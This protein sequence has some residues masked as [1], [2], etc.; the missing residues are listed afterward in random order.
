MEYIVSNIAVP[1]SV[2]VS[3]HLWIRGNF[4]KN[5]DFLYLLDGYVIDYRIKNVVEYLNLGLE[6]HYANGA[7]NIFCFDKQNGRLEI[8]T[9]KRATL[10]LYLYEKDGVFAY[11]NNP[12]LLVKY[13]YDSISISVES[14]KSQLLYFT[15]YH[16]TRTLFT[17]ISRVDGATYICYDILRNSIKKH[18]YWDFTYMPDSNLGIKT[19]LEKVDSDF[20]YYFET[21]KN[22]NEG[23]LAG[24]GCSGGLDS[25]IIA[26]YLHKVGIRSRAYVFGDEKPHRFLRST[27]AKTSEM[28]GSSYGFKVDFI[29]YRAE[30]ITRS[31]ILDIRN[32]PFVYSQAYINPYDDMPSF[33]Y[34]FV[35]DPGGLAYMADYVLTGNSLKLKEHADYFIGYRHWAMTGIPSVLRKAAMHLKIPFNPYSD[36]GVLGLGRSAITRVIDPRTREVCREELYACIDGFG[37]ENNIEK[38]VRIHDKITAKYQYSA[39]YSSVSHTKRSYQLYYPF[40]YDTIAS[41]PP[42]YFKDKFFLKKIIEFV[43]PDLLKIPDQNLNIIGG[44]HGCI[45]KFRNRIELAMRGRGLN[46]LHLLRTPAYRK[47]AYGVFNRD[48]PVFYS[49]VDRK[50]LFKSGLIEC[51]AGVQ[52]LK[53]KMLLDIFYYRELDV[54]LSDRQ[55]EKPEW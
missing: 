23:Q 50:R 39:G 26:H 11:S 27:T 49:V 43:N 8:K 16:P 20:T 17:N 42:E 21:V 54:L 36:T 30:W 7:Y 37:G 6:N 51:Y 44:I 32:D 41:M 2:Q 46:F 35:G 19:F 25:R 55:Y 1:E 12:W 9:D 28:V 53:L 33:D 52:Y 40:F 45:G 4:K 47:C 18:R 14:L 22:R 24:F 15:D 29:P 13:F 31:L 34:M 10:S 48:N 3:T 5:G 38:W